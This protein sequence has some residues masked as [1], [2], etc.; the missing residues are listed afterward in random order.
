[1]PL[2]RAV[3]KMVRYS[4]CGFGRMNHVGA[5]QMQIGQGFTFVT[6]RNLRGELH[7]ACTRAAT[8][9]PRDI[10]KNG[11]NALVQACHARLQIL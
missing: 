10:G 5:R 3:F 7:A 4:S 11:S 9:A 8:G 6:Y 1:M 2:S